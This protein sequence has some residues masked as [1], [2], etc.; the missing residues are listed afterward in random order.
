ME[1]IKLTPHG[2]EKRKRGRP[3]KGEAGAPKIVKEKA[4]RK[5]MSD[6]HKAKL[7]AGREAARRERAEAGLTGKAKKEKGIINK[8]EMPIVWITGRE[9]D[10]FEFFKPIRAAF[11]GIHDYVS[12]PIIIKQITRKPV[13]QDT[14]AILEILN[15]H[16]VVKV[17]KKHFMT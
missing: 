7:K 1:N 15:K 10:A 14:A 16:A 17:I 2:E 3:K 11:R 6:E 4:P 12:S 8:G 5:P 9:K 13:W